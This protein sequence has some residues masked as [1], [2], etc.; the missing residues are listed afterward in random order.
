MPN[1]VMFASSGAGTSL[2]NAANSSADLQRLGE[3]RVG[4]GVEVQLRPAHGVVEAVHAAGV[5]AGDDDEVRV[6]PGG[7]GGADLRRHLLRLDQ[8]LAG[9]MPAP[10]RHLLVFEVNPGDA[11]RLEQPHRALDVQRFAE[12]GVGVA[13]QRQRRGLRDQLG[14]RA[15]N[16]VSVSRPMSGTPLPAESAPPER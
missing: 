16:S 7:D 8:R 2:A 3:D 5:G 6:A 1:S 14:L 9:Q 11:G 4:P 15:T 12:A 13:E 10:L